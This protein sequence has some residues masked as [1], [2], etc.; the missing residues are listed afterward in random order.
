MMRKD[1]RRSLQI[2]G[3]G[4][5]S[6]LLVQRS[7]LEQMLTHRYRSAPVHRHKQ[8]ERGGGRIMM[9][10]SVFDIEAP[11]TLTFARPPIQDSVLAAWL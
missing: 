1:K 9:G 2:Q 8:R 5:Q 6:S 4:M 10:P 7:Q 11:A 3:G